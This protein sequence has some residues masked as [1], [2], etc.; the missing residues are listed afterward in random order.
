VVI[1]GNGNQVNDQHN[2]VMQ[3]LEAYRNA[4]SARDIEAF[5]ALYDAD[6]HL[7]DTWDRFEQ[8]GADAWR[9]MVTDWFGSH[10]DDVLEVRFDDVHA[11]V[12]EDVAF[13]HAAL[14]FAARSV[15]VASHGHVTRYTTGLERKDGAWKIVHEHTSI[16]VQYETGKGI[17]SR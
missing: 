6:V 2:P 12:G 15:G 8:T 3:V 4:V 9:E 1:K 10:P 13:V 16:P 17:F 5:M 7:F 11:V 14:S